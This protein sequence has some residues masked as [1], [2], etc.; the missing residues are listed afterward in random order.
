MMAEIPTHYLIVLA[1]LGLYAVDCL[2]LEDERHVV[3]SCGSTGRV[4]AAIHPG[5]VTIILGKILYLL[6]PLLPWMPLRR[7]GIRTP[8][9]S[10]G[11]D[12]G[13]GDGPVLATLALASVHAGC[14]LAILVFGGRTSALLAALAVMY[15]AA[16][17]HAIYCWRRVR[18]FPASLLLQAFL[19]PPNALN[20]VRRATLKSPARALDEVLRRQLSQLERHRF[21]E[22]ARPLAE[23]AS[24]ETGAVLRRLL[25]L[26][27]TT[28]Q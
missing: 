7:A 24:P 9:P 3:C 10:D 4:F 5:R 2:H 17:V 28:P 18:E 23:A 6:P 13:P 20:A 19:C 27:E 16:M 1:F 21:V 14:L 15:V 26:P 12:E 8:G 22:N 25:G 11:G